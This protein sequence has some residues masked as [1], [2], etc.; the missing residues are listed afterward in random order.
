MSGN[1]ITYI[2]MM[3]MHNKDQLCVLRWNTEKCKCVSI[4]WTQKGERTHK[5]TGDLRQFGHQGQLGEKVQG[6]WGH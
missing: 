1:T 4:Q 5:E 6:C 3:N 2:S